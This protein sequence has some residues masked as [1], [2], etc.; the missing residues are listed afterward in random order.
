MPESAHCARRSWLL[1][2]TLV[3]IAAEAPSQSM[4]ESALLAARA[5]LARI[6]QSLSG[7]DAGSELSRVN[8]LAASDPQPISDD[9]RRVLSCA[10]DIATRSRGVFDP[11][12]GAQVAALGF[13]PPQAAAP[14]VASWRDVELSREAL[15]YAKPLVLDLG[16]IAKGYAVDCAIDALRVNGATAGRVNAGGDLRVFGTRGEPVHVRTGGPQGALFP[17]VT[18]VDGAVATSAYGGQR[19]RR[20]RRWAAPLIDPRLRLPV[21]STR[22]VS[23]IASTCMV[24]DAL[25]KVVALL[26]RGAQG[27]LR[28][29]RADAVVLSPARGRWRCTR[30]E[31]TMVAGA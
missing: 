6:H 8:A 22:T 28:A 13:L 17:L 25:T 19:R 3:E 29:Y 5:E 14:G 2:G 12:V 24:A 18:L 15:R 9:L 23:V 30:L 1:L 4:L 10:L 16:G 31:S 11:T 7:H 26:G 20:D 21:L 27:I